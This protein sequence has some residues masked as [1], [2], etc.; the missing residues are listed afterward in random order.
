MQTSPKEY[1]TAL[2]VSVADLSCETLVIIKNKCYHVKKMPLNRCYY[3]Q[4]IH[5]VMLKSSNP[6]VS[7]TLIHLKIT[8]APA[9]K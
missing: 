5:L 6:E 2:Q 7:R 9:V 8:Q 3:H 4:K 1:I